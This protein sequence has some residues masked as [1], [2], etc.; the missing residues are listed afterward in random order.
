MT[1]FLVTVQAYVDT[2]CAT[3]ADNIAAETARYLEEANET[4]HAK[5]TTIQTAVAEKAPFR[6]LGERFWAG[7]SCEADIVAE[8]ETGRRRR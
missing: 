7:Q 6:P 4:P 5:D 8:E 1:K 3:T 2:D